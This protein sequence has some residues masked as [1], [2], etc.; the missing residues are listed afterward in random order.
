MG[1]GK[2]DLIRHPLVHFAVIGVALYA[3]LAIFGS[4]RDPSSYRIVV[5]DG[6]LD[7]LIAAFERRWRRPPTPA[8]LRSAVDEHVR[9]E[10]LVREAIAGGLDREDMVVRR[11]LRQKV[12]FLTNETQQVPEPTDA[13]LE[14]FVARHPDRVPQW[15]REPA[16]TWA[17]RATTGRSAGRDLLR[18]AVRNEWFAA[19]RDEALDTQYRTLRSRYRIVIER[20]GNK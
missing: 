8:E 7:A 20:E 12:E 18:E 16:R 2:H 17:L 3:A 6:Q 4:R 19:R 14:A 5:T 9:E 15:S 1:N 13:E 11:R 10:V